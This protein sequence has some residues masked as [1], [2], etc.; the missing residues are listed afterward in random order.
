MTEYFGEFSD[1]YDFIIYRGKCKILTVKLCVVYTQMTK[2][3][4]EFSDRYN[5][6]M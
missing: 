5:F 1:R 3:L 2:F 6:I 4:G